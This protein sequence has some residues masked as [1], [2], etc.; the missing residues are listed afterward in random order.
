M[1]VLLLGMYRK[2]GCQMPTIFLVMS[3]FQQCVFAPIFDVD[4]MIQM[5]CYKQKVIQTYACVYV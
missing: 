2:L 5:M 1:M 4:H 3:N